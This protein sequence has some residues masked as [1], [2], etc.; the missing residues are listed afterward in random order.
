[1]SGRSAA[2]RKEALSQPPEQQIAKAKSHFFQFAGSLGAYQMP[3][4]LTQTVTAAAQTYPRAAG[5]P[6]KELEL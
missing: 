4:Y 1:M 6:K 3:L 2:P 5:L